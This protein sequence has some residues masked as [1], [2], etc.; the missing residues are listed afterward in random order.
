[1]KRTDIT[2]DGYGNDKSIISLH[3]R[4]MVREEQPEKPTIWKKLTNNDHYFHAL[5]YLLVAPELRE[6]RDHVDKTDKRTSVIFGGATIKDK[7]N[8][9]S[10]HGMT[11]SSKSKLDKIVT[12]RVFN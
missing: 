11:K 10:L 5:A 3:L 1:M 8:L 9:D 4:D 7:S 6:L 12:T 2:F